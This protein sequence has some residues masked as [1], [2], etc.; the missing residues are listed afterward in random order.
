MTHCPEL[1]KGRVAGLGSDKRECQKDLC[2]PLGEGVAT[3]DRFF[4]TKNAHVRHQALKTRTNISQG[5]LRAVSPDCLLLFSANAG[6]SNRPELVGMVRAVLDAAAAIFHS[7]SLESQQRRGWDSN[8]ENSSGPACNALGSEGHKGCAEK[9]KL[10]TDRAE[11]AVQAAGLALRRQLQSGAVR[12]AW[13]EFV[14]AL[15]YVAINVKGKSG[16]WLSFVKSWVS[17]LPKPC[18]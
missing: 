7:A 17:A 18:Q 6:R 5:K 11:Q 2:W 8:K 13:R 14:S 12:Y 15:L 10:P 9:G 4:A 16:T 1:Q 3:P